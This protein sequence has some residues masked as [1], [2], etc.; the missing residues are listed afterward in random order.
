MKHEEPQNAIYFIS[1]ENI[2]LVPMT[3]ISVHSVQATYD[4]N[5]YAYKRG[6]A[7]R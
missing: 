6:G 4:S 2:V 7:G 3:S 5:L 1:L